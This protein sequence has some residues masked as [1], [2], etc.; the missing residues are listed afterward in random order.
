MAETFL[1]HP[2]T[3]LHQGGTDGRV[4]VKQADHAW[5]TR[6]ELARTKGLQPMPGCEHLVSTL[7]KLPAETILEVVILEGQ[8]KL[9]AFWFVEQTGDPVG[10]IVGA[11]ATYDE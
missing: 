1:Q 9:G 4:T 7:N 3:H 10:F 8:G 5:G 6:L 11:P 2:G